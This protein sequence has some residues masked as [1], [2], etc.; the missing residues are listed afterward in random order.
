MSRSA[1]ATPPAPY[2]PPR[3]ATPTMR[4]ASAPTV[5]AA[6]FAQRSGH[7]HTGR[8]RVKHLPNSFSR[9]GSSSSKKAATE[10]L[11]LSYEN[12]PAVQ[13]EQ[14][15]DVENAT[16]IAR[17]ESLAF[18]ATSSLESSLSASQSG[19]SLLSS[20]VGSVH[21]EQEEEMGRLTPTPSMSPS[22]TASFSPT[23]LA[24]PASSRAPSLLLQEGAVLDLNNEGL[25]FL[26]SGPSPIP[27]AATLN[28][29]TPSRASWVPNFGKMAKAVVNTGM[30]MGMSFGEKR[31]KKD[32]N[33]A[34]RQIDSNTFLLSQPVPR[35]NA[36]DLQQMPEPQATARRR[37]WAMAEQRRVQECARL[38]SQWPQSGYSLAKW[39]SNGECFDWRSL[40]AEG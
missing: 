6:H 38:C 28:Q 3:N 24:T 19:S 34:P 15:R 7:H 12:I 39:V 26:G 4:H 40:Q 17:N 32:V 31:I 14:A 21:N 18:F 10:A 33:N 29:P 20:S 37:Q 13:A 11:G 1:T 22:D 27:G 8:R 2:F 36:G 5:S 25:A 9:L 23:P 30:S 35:P 16:R